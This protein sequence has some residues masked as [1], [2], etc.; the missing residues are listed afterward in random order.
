MFGLGRFSV[1]SSVWVWGGW[2]F[3]LLQCFIGLLEEVSP[4]SLQRK[5]LNFKSQSMAM[6]RYFLDKPLL[7][8]PNKKAPSPCFEGF[9]LTLLSFASR[10]GLT[11]LITF[12]VS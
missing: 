8:S 6:G 4:I 3:D 5:G 1:S 10:L 11:S 7:K 2:L 12:Q 9:F